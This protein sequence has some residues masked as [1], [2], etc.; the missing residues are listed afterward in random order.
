M[1]VI[2]ALDRYDLA[3]FT[4]LESGMCTFKWPRYRW[5]GFH[6]KM[7]LM[8]WKL[9]TKAYVGELVQTLDWWEDDVIAGIEARRAP[10]RAT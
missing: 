9:P 10:A 8:H 2:C 3:L 4:R 5:N 1:I 6:N 7:H